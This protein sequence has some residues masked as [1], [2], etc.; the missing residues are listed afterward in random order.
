MLMSEIVIQQYNIVLTR[1]RSDS[2]GYTKPTQVYKGMT[3]P[4]TITYPSM[5]MEIHHNGN[6]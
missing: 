1:P 6:Q 4:W 5:H 3:P 2:H